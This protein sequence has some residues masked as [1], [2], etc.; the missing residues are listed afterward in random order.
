M[1]ICSFEDV[2]ATFDKQEEVHVI[3]LP[4]KVLQLTGVELLSKQKLVVPT[5][6]PC[7]YLLRCEMLSAFPLL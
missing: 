3:I 2:I 6:M 7:V 4:A 1:T 5:R